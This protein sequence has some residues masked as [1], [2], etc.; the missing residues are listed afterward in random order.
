MKVKLIISAF[1]AI[2]FFGC[3]SNE[4]KNEEVI[5]ETV[6]D[7]VSVNHSADSAVTIVNNPSLLWT[8][9]MQQNSKLE[10]LKKP[11]N[12]SMLESFSPTQLIAALNENFSDVQLQLKK[13]S[14]DTIYVSI[15]DSKKLTQEMGSTG[16]ENYLASAVY[17][18]TELKNVKYVNFEMK[19]GDHAGPGVFSRTD[20]KRLK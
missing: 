4:D 3:N 11:A 18:L 15:P 8:V 16:A 19:E 9:E 1:V 17:N 12:D 6:R 7:T 13:I 5:H 2:V 14:H 10:K 20:F